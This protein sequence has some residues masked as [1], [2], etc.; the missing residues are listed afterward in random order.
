MKTLFKQ[1]LLL[2]RDPVILCLLLIGGI[3]SMVVLFILFRMGYTIGDIKPAIDLGI[4]YISEYPVLVYLSILLVGGLPLPL[5]PF[6]LLAGVLFTNRYGLFVALMLCYSAMF[7]NMVWTYFLSAY[8]M[9]SVFERILLKFADKFPEIPEAH[10]SKVAMIIRITPGIPFFLQNYFLGVSRV[11]FVKYLLISVSIQLFYTTGFVVG[12]G[13]IFEGKAGLAIAAFS[14]FVILGIV[15]N[16]V[17]SK[18][19]KTDSSTAS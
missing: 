17:R 4:S 15:L 9:R 14:I 10:K 13:A 5:S 18:G 8:P 7:L 12:G 2:L 19:K 6:L 3:G 11:P 1:V 16:V